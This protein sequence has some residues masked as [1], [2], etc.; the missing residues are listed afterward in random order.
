MSL[1]DLVIKIVKN[2][3]FLIAILYLICAIVSKEDL[4]FLTVAVIASFIFK[5]DDTKS[6]VY[7]GDSNCS[8]H[9]D[10]CDH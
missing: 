1:K 9:G 5:T 10:G 2:K 4:G 3:Y 6:D 8:H 7:G